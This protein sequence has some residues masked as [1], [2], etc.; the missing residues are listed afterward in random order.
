MVSSEP[1]EIGTM[2]LGLGTSLVSFHCLILTAYF[3][4]VVE[5]GR[6]FGD[7]LVFGRGGCKHGPTM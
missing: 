5:C 1:S 6:L 7:I 2:S 4:F 3:R